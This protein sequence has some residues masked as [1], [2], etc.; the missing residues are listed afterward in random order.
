M[1]QI[2]AEVA[3]LQLVHVRVL[4]AHEEIAGHDAGALGPSAGSGRDDELE[5]GVRPLQGHAQGGVLG[6]D[7]QCELQLP[8]LDEGHE[9][10]ALGAQQLEG[11]LNAQHLRARTVDGKDAVA[12]SHAGAVA[13]A[14]RRDRLHCQPLVPA[15]LQ[16]QAEAGHVLLDA[17][18][19]A[20]ARRRPAQV[21]VVVDVGPGLGGGGRRPGR[22]RRRLRARPLE[23][24]PQRP[25]VL[26][27]LYE[28]PRRH[29]LDGLVVQREDP[30]PKVDF[31]TARPPPAA[32]RSH[33]HRAGRG[34]VEAHA[35][36]AQVRRRHEAVLRAGRHFSNLRLSGAV[37]RRGSEVVGGSRREA[38]RVPPRERGPDVQGH[39]HRGLAADVARLA[40]ALRE[41]QH[42]CR[43]PGDPR[44]QV[45]QRALV[46]GPVEARDGPGPPTRRPCP[47][48]GD[49]RA[50]ACGLVVRAAGLLA[51]RLV[52][53]APIE[54]FI[55]VGAEQLPMHQAAVGIL[56]HVLHLLRLHVQELRVPDGHVRL[57]VVG[58]LGRVFCI[59]SGHVPPHKL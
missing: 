4:H 44:R 36:A 50:G 59:H 35:E 5:V 47:C 7:S 53:V 32:H 13:P 24:Q 37:P 10:G 21:A 17:D 18:A 39:R 48:L 19:V 25:A 26:G 51:P 29:A 43:P 6:P 9:Q 3:D 41:A 34:A 12:H 58:V 49:H 2:A 8:T 20:A 55:V 38:L 56:P 28:S 14:T 54:A 33:G 15:G 46:L 52:G 16:G 23:E 11:L 22:L 40:V 27:Q 57:P 45:V 31:Q 30:V 1:L 42:L